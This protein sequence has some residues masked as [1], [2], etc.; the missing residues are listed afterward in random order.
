MNLHVDLRSLPPEEARAFCGAARR[1]AR[2]EP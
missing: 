1:K 2:P